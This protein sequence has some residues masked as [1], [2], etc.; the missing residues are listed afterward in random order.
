L[1]RALF[2]GGV[3]P[4]GKGK[5]GGSVFCMHHWSEGRH[6]VSVRFGGTLSE[7]EDNITDR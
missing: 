3:V 4:K 6:K 7:K 1:K 5:E 2:Y